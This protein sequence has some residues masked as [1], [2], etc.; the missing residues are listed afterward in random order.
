[1]AQREGVI[2]K[3]ALCKKVQLLYLQSR[4][5][6]IIR[7]APE[8]LPFLVQGV[9][10][11]VQEPPVRLWMYLRPNN[12]KSGRDY[13]QMIDGHRVLVIE[14]EPLWVP[15]S[16]LNGR[17]IDFIVRDEVTKD[18]RLI[19]VCSDLSEGET[20]RRELLAMREAKAE[21]GISDCVIVTDGEERETEDGIKIVPAWKWLLNEGTRNC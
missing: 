12:V 17:E 18:E 13:G 16:S 1:M 2:K 14:Y 20:E 9:D 15:I 5:N 3:S 21:T 7:Y 19:Q 8:F 6:A 4:I 10:L 11:F